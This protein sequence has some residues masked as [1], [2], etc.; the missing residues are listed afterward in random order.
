MYTAKGI[1]TTFSNPCIWRMKYLPSVR[2]FSV[3]SKIRNF[4]L[5]G[6]FKEILTP[7]YL[8]EKANR[9]DRDGYTILDE[10]YSSE[11]IDEFRN[12][13][14]KLIQE[15][16]A[17][18][19]SS[20]LVFDGKSQSEELNKSIDYFLKS[21]SNISF[22][23]ESGVFDENGKLKRPIKQWLNKIGYAIHDIN[24]Y[25]KKFSYSNVI[26]TICAS[27]LKYR[28]PILAQSMYI[29]K[30]AKVGGEII[31][32]QDSSYLTTN[33]LTCK[34]F[35]FA[36]DDAD[37]NNGWLWG[38]PGSHKTVPINSFWKLK[39]EKRRKLVLI[40][41]KYKDYFIVYS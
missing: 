7:S 10:L 3:L 5:E 34:G 36:L 6:R 4:P 33:P 28:N 32:H 14:D 39:T 19:K 26:K 11:M 23:Y 29:F 15:E 20:P 17:N 30:S 21:A 22:L 25:Y 37:E 9:F 41:K 2:Y 13:M 18:Q 31:P 12:E 27:I 16:E 38:I 40:H 8:E 1:K 35:W 24:P